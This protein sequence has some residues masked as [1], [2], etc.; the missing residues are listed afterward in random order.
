MEL[1]VEEEEKSPSRR[2]WVWN[3]K[4]RG[5]LEEK[6]AVLRRLFPGWLLGPTEQPPWAGQGQSEKKKLARKHSGL[7][8]GATTMHGP[9]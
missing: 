7:P 6:L 4:Y 1:G 2:E 8:I 3:K 9:R 5:S